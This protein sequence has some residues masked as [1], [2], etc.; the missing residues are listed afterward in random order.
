MGPGTLVNLDS[1][2]DLIIDIPLDGRLEASAPVSE[3][4]P[5]L[6]VNKRC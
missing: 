4:I 6:Q 1:E 5:T 2:H 3:A